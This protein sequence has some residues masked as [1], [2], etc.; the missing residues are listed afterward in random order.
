MI[1]I[2]NYTLISINHFKLK[3]DIYLNFSHNVRTNIKVFFYYII[4]TILFL[5]ITIKYFN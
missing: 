5:T 3:L 2:L 1:G 4:Y